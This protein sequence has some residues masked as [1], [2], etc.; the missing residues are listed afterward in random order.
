M[1]RF[2][3]MTFATALAITA[4]GGGGDITADAGEDFS[5]PVGEAPVFDGCGSSGELSNYQWTIIEAPEGN[6]DDNGKA[7]R[8]T[9]DSCNFELETAMV[10]DDIGEWTIELA[11]TD[12]SNEVTDQVVVTVTE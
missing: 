7:L 12:G 3:A 5:V 1:R 10:V 2:A 11:V 4:C 8:T 6:A 9:M